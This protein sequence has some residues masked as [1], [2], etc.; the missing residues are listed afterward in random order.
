MVIKTVTLK[1]FTKRSPNFYFPLLLKFFVV[2]VHKNLFINIFQVS[3][4]SL[5]CHEDLYHLGNM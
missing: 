2:I 5:D 4:D 1:M 3:V